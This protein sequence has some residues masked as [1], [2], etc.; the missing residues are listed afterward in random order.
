MLHSVAK[1]CDGLTIASAHRSVRQEEVHPLG[2]PVDGPDTT[3]DPFELGPALLPKS[4][5][6]LRDQPEPRGEALKSLGL[7]QAVGRGAS[8]EEVLRLIGEQS[9]SLANDLPPVDVPSRRCFEQ[10][11]LRSYVLVCWFVSG[12]WA[13]WKIAGDRLQPPTHAL[14]IIHRGVSPH[15]DDEKRCSE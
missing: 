1:C 3:F 12:F 4:V 8:D 6:D 7:I 10:S 11:D 2:Q 15:G 5:G 14:L 13:S 9:L